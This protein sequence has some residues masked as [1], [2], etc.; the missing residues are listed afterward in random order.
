MITLA[1]ADQALCEVRNK[2]LADFSNHLL[3]EGLTVDD[4][5]FARAMLSYMHELEAWRHATYVDL[6]QWLQGEQE[7]RH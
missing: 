2:A 4:P 3:G 7:T 6:V 5:A 1:Q